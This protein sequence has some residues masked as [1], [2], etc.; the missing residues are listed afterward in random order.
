MNYLKNI[1]LFPD[2]KQDNHCITDYCYNN[3]QCVN[4]LVG[5]IYPKLLIIE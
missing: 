1:D 5:C 2:H 4:E 3:S